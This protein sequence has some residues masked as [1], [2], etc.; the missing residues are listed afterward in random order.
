MIE[1]LVKGFKAPPKQIRIGSRPET[2]RRKFIDQLGDVG[3]LNKVNLAGFYRSEAKRVDRDFSKESLG[4]FLPQ[5]IV[6]PEFVHVLRLHDGTLEIIH[7]RLFLV[8]QLS[9]QNKTKTRFVLGSW[10]IM[11]ARTCPCRAAYSNASGFSGSVTGIT[12]DEMCSGK[13][14]IWSIMLD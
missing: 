6:G 1:H 8:P 2:G 12:V 7:Q 4:D 11:Q 13:A 9:F 14:S 5:D 10:S 3:C